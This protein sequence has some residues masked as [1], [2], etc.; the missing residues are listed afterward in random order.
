LARAAR[1][2]A[3][4][5]CFLTITKAAADADDELLK[6]TARKSRMKAFTHERK[7]PA[8]AAAIFKAFHDQTV[9][10]QWYAPDGF[11]TSSH[12][13]EFKPGGKWVFSMHGPNGANYLNEMVF[14]EIVEPSKI[15][16]RHGVQP[17][18]TATITI[19]DAGDDAVITF[20]QD[21]DSEELAEAIA[22]VVQPANEQ[23]LD[24]LQA[25]VAIG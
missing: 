1:T 20:Y 2:A 6:Q 21:F 4:A 24:K 12:S 15:V 11:T 14:Q 3:V 17:Y 9:L 16:M 19:E 22:Y 10:C 7:I 18:F 23:I 5:S 8:P 25:I 13:F